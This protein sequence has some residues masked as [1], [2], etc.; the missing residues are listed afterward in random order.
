[1]RDNAEVSNF[2][3]KETLNILAFLA[4]KYTVYPTFSEEKLRYSVCSFAPRPSLNTEF[5]T[6]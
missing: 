1:M 4:S 2:H 3:K 6:S 5:T